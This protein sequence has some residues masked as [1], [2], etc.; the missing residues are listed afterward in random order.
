MYSNLM[1]FEICK[2]CGYSHPP[3]PGGT[4]TKCPMVKEKTSTGQEINF[5]YLFIPLKNILISQIKKRNI[6]DPQKLFGQ[7]IL[8][9]T[10]ITEN[11]KETKI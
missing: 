8:E 9:I 5:E 3:I 6:Q 2:E 1:S 11:Y 7:I 10:K 4:G